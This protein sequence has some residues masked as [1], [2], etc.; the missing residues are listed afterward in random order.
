MKDIISKLVSA[1]VIHGEDAANA[2]QI[3]LME[4]QQIYEIRHCYF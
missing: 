4:K 2:L 3:I 1:D